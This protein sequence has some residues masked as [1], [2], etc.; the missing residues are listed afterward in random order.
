MKHFYRLC[1]L[2]MM[3]L[4]L[5]AL[6]P[7][8]TAMGG[9]APN[10]IMVVEQSVESQFRRHMT[11][12]IKAKS[13]AGNITSARL[14][15]QIRAFGSSSSQRVTVR[16]PDR[17]VELAYKWNTVFETTPPFQVV[18][19]RWQLTDDAGNSFTTERYQTEFTDESRDWQSLSDPQQRVTVYWYDQD[20]DFGEF[21]LDVTVRGYEHVAKATGYTPAQEL[22]VVMANN[23]DD[24]CES[25]APRQ[26]LDWYAGVTFGSL[27]LQYLIPG[28]RRFVMRQVVPHELA[29][30]FLN[31]WLGG[32]IIRV[33]RWFNEGQATLN[34]LEGQDLELER[35][36]NMAQEGR[37]FRLPMMEREAVSSR[38][39][40]SRTADWYAQ[41]TSM[42]AFLYEQ[43][44]LE[45]LGAI[46]K[47]VQ[48]G[49]RFDT[50]MQRHTG[51]TME[52]FEQAWRD[53]VGSEE[54]IPTLL[55][56]WTLVFPPTPTYEPTLTPRP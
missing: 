16:N 50:A 5:V 14:I 51:L 20:E 12:N 13:T 45:S 36:S 54:E 34:E 42:V 27:T 52:Q 40:S 49:V 47:R 32:N 9:D 19:Y 8:Q 31:D 24:F 6:F 35:A 17:E 29:H 55:P 18:Y 23:Q 21:L 11:F 7:A 3:A 48:D 30:A 2:V 46:V 41:S 1:I 25:F 22:R 44:G 15:W 26:C 37:L 38:D 4:G 39:S 33:P 10:P 56:T 43:W 28:E 53:W